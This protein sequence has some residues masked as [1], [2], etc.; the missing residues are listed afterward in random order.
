MRSIWRS[1]G[2]TWA[3]WAAWSSAMASAV[4]HMCR[5][6]FVLLDFHDLAFLWL[7]PPSSRMA[8]SR[9]PHPPSA[10]GI[11]S[12]FSSVPPSNRRVTCR[13]PS[14]THDGRGLGHPHILPLQAIEASAAFASLN[15]PRCVPPWS[16]SPSRARP[17]VL[18]AWRRSDHGV[19]AGKGASNTEDQQWPMDSIRR[20]WWVAPAALVGSPTHVVFRSRLFLPMETG[21]GGYLAWW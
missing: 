10:P 5:L 11:A 6:L 9:R 14:S 20:L 4:L 12:A 3:R 13:R 19:R 21:H 17:A 8:A 15:C 2:R 18:D 7:G 1:C 16:A